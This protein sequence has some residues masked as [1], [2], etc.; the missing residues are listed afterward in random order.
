MLFT[1]TSLSGAYLV[2]PERHTDSRGYFAR[3]WC[4]D[5]FAQMGLNPHL[6]QCS[7]SFNLKAG[8]L[9]GMHYQVAP[10]AETKLVR[11]TRG[12]IFDVIVDL[13]PG[14]PTYANWLS[15]EL[16]QE[17]QRAIYIPENFAHGFQTLV[18]N[19]EVFYQMSEFYHPECS[20]GFCWDDPI[21]QI[22]WP[23]VDHR[24]VS[25]KD[26]SYAPYLEG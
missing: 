15:V 10:F 12:A 14:S 6:V 7:T 11:C 8:T 25:E 20:R 26:Q 18:D 23:E 9:R 2:D 5:E 24:T 4:Q 21:F 13:R 22:S 17:N 1:K 3:T 19:A 16:N